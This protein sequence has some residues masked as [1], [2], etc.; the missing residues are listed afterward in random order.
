[1]RAGEVIAKPAEDAYFMRVATELLKCFPGIANPTMKPQVAVQLTTVAT[2]LEE[3]YRLTPTVL[4]HQPVDLLKVATA[5]AAPAVTATSSLFAILAVEAAAA[6]A[7]H[8]ELEGEPVVDA[9]SAPHAKHTA[10]RT[11]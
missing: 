2:V 3:S 7:L 8:T 9:K 1:M 10:S 5:P 4:G 11:S 6:G